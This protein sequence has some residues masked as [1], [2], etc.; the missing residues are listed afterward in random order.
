[1][2]LASDKVETKHFRVCSYS[3]PDAYFLRFKLNVSIEP[4]SVE[5]DIGSMYSSAAKNLCE[6][7]YFS[8]ALS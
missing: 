2:E 7:L 3:C 5:E 4:R 6:Q 1:M 8:K